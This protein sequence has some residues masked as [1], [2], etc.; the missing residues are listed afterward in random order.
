MKIAPGITPLRGEHKNV[1]VVG[2]VVH[3]GWLKRSRELSDVLLSFYLSAKIHQF[4]LN[5]T[6]H[7]QVFPTTE[8]HIRLKLL[9]K[10]SSR[11][12]NLALVT[13]GSSPA[14]GVAV[15]LKINDIRKMKSK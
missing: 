3:D 13:L 15:Q 14:S 6:C 9:T 7:L 5:K 12:K 8:S 11:M 2:K 10:N 1:H 4:S